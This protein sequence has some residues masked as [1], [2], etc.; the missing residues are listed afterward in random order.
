MK[1]YYVDFSGYCEIEAETPE[2]A[3]AKFWWLIQ[4]EIPLPRNIYEIDSVEE[5]DEFNA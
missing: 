3:K 1:K 2:Q 4:E 5:K